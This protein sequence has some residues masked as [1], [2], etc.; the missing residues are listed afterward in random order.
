[1]ITQVVMLSRASAWELGDVDTFFEA[2]GCL[3]TK[4]APIRAQ[5][6]N[7]IDSGI[8]SS[9]GLN[10][11]DENNCKLQAQVICLC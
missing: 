7:N 2:G 3:P 1:M 10:T 6:V 11:R 4:N 5:M 8:I 9:R